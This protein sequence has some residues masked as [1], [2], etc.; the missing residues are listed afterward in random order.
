MRRLGMLV[1]AELYKAAK[2][3]AIELGISL[4]V[5]MTELIRKDIEKDA[6]KEKE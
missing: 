4:T 1:D 2:I 3:K 5:Y 6:Q